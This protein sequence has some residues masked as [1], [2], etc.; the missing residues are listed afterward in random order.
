MKKL[1]YI[2]SGLLIAG[3]SAFFSSCGDNE[4][5][6]GPHT[7]TDDEIAE[8][9]RQDSIKQAQR[10]RIDADLILEYTVEFYLSANSYDGAEVEIDMDKIANEFGIS[11]DDLGAALNGDGGPDVTGFAIEGS[12]HADNMTSSNSGAYWGHWWDKD[13]NVKTGAMRPWS[14]LSSGMRTAGVSST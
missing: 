2:L 1:S 14:S 5:F 4:N 11:K 3:C 12:T 7:L 10:E 13:G 6:W 9:A 8:M